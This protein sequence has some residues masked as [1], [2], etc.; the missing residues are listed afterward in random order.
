MTKSREEILKINPSLSRFILD[1]QMSYR[2]DPYEEGESILLDID[3]EIGTILT[4]E[5]AESLNREQNEEFEKSIDKNPFTESDKLQLIDNRLMASSKRDSLDYLIDIAKALEKIRIEL[6][7]SELIVIGIQNIP[8]LVQ[9]NDY[10]PVKNALNYLK[11]R[12]E[13]EF[14]GGFLLKEDEIIEFIPH[15][16]WLTRCNASLPYFYMSFP[17]SKTVI[18]I[19]KYGVLHLEFYNQNEK[20]RILKI[21]SDLNFVELNDCQDPIEFDLFNGREIISSS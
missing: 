15:L 3:D 10:P 13:K 18:T 20:L 11:Q 2:P 6:K 21:L 7:E 14:S 8:W 12:I 17:N 4:K 19:C 16:F 1:L 9:D 5:L